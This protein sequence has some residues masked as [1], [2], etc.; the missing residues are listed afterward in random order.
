MLF[1][2]C[3]FIIRMT[4]QTNKQTKQT[5]QTTSTKQNKTECPDNANAMLV[6]LFLMALLVATLFLVVSG[7]RS[8]VSSVGIGFNLFQVTALFSGFNLDWPDA[9]LEVFNVLSSLNFNFDLFSPECS[10]KFII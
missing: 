4:Q 7:G 10:G 6:V 9:L 2:F 5:K 8:R 1:I 3:R